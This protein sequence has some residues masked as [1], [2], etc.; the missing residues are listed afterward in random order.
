MRNDKKLL[1]VVLLNLLTIN[2]IM[3]RMI[4]S[5]GRILDEED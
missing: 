3:N 4:R 5:L 2:Q 1:K